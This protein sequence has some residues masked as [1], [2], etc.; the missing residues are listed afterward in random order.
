MTY[1]GEE[2]GHSYTAACAG[3]RVYVQRHGVGDETLKAEVMPTGDEPSDV[4]Q[5]P[6]V[7]HL[8]ASLAAK[9]DSAQFG[10]FIYRSAFSGT[11][12]LP[13][14]LDINATFFISVSCIYASPYKRQR[15]QH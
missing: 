7:S 14:D 6:E 13:I 2:S 1:A 4:S 15:P 8:A 5:I 9:E 12:F 11:I 3:K 10:G